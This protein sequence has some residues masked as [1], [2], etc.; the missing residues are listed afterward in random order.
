MGT[1]DMR[2][3]N[4]GVFSSQPCL[5]FAGQGWVLLWGWG[6]WGFSQGRVRSHGKEVSEPAAELPIPGSLWNGSFAPAAKPKFT[7]MSKEKK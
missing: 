5:W 3:N 2:R 7:G 4:G 1:N 6:S